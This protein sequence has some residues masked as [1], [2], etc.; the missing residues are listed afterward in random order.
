MSFQLI[1]FLSP[2]QIFE[3]Y[4]KREDKSRPPDFEKKALC[5]VDPSIRFRETSTLQVARM[6]IANNFDPRTD[7]FHLAVFT[8]SRWAGQD[9]VF[10]QAYSV[11]VELAHEKCNTLYQRCSDLVADL[12][13]R[14]DL[15]A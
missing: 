7:L 11:G 4:R 6:N 12:Q 8:H 5:T 14:V 1:R 13:Q 10:R 2:D 15:N 9:D 3:Q